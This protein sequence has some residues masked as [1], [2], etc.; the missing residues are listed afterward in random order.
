V[1]ARVCTEP[2]GPGKVKNRERNMKKIVYP[3]IKELI[4]AKG[5]NLGWGSLYGHSTYGWL[6]GN[7]GP[8][9][10]WLWGRKNGVSVSVQGL[11]GETY[12]LKGERNEKN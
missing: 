5:Q 1:Q 9:K 2:G 8:L 11:T 4:S 3:T 6:A 10:V 12:N 7:K